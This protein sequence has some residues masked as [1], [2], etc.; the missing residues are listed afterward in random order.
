[1]QNH[2]IEQK[3]A[4]QDRIKR[5]HNQEIQDMRDNEMNTLR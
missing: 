4:F 5:Q 3:D 1:M 2:L